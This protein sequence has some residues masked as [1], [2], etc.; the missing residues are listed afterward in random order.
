MA[1]DVASG[2]TAAEESGP[3]GPAEP[4]DPTTVDGPTE[5]GDAT[6][7]DGPTQLGDPTD[8]DGPTQLGDTADADGPT[9]LGDPT[10]AD[11]AVVGDGVVAG[12]DEDGSAVVDLGRRRAARR[13]RIAGIA[14]VAAA[15]AAAVVFG[16][17]LLVPSQH[18]GKLELSGTALAPQA[19]AR[20][21]AVSLDA[22]AQ[23]TLYIDGLPP[24]P[25][26]TYY[27]AWLL[28][29]SARIPL[30]SFH[31]HKPGA[32]VV[33]SGVDWAGAEVTVTRQRIDAGLVP[34]ERL[35]DGRFPPA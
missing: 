25:D 10:D 24:A 5:L 30:G 13:R 6:D 2:A 28:R 14:A 18:T 27:E 9:Q 11:R 16:L 29:G 32:V 1:A 7:A 34:G 15:A 12:P 22:G 17:S 33:W 4:G 35:L 8:V 3:D 20:V 21:A 19:R 31:L 23:F 26:G